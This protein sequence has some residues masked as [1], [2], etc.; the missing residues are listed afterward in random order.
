[1]N[2]I[3]ADIQTCALLSRGSK[4]I[5]VEISTVYGINLMSF[6][7]VCRQVWKFSA[8]LGSVTSAPKFCR[9]KYARSPK[10]VRKKLFLVKSDA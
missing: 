5:Y 4:D 9:S 8:G 1:M 7:T 2:K 3:R 10:I 6:S